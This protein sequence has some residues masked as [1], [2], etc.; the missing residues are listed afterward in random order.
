VDV[1]KA[2]RRHHAGVGRAPGHRRRR[3][4]SPQSRA[5]GGLNNPSPIPGASSSLTRSVL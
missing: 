5:P 4:S 2:L 3:F 1:R